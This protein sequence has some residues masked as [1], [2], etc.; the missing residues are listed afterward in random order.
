MAAAEVDEHLARLAAHPGLF[1]RE[2]DGGALRPVERGDEFAQLVEAFDWGWE[3]IRWA[4]IN[5]MKSAFL[6]FDQ[7]LHLINDIIKPRYALFLPD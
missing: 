3:E 7:R 1:G 6:P 4:T 2:R 5:G